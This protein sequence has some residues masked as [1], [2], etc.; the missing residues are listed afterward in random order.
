MDR[1]D[2]EQKGIYQVMAGKRKAIYF[3]ILCLFLPLTTPF[4][5]QAAPRAEYTMP[6]HLIQTVTQQDI[7]EGM[8]ALGMLQCPVLETSDCEKAFE[9]VKECVVRV[10][11]GNAYGSGILWELT[12]DRVVIATNRHVLEYWQAADSYLLFPQGYYLE[13]EILGVSEQ[14][15]VGF[16]AVDSGQFTYEA[17]KELR[18][19][20]ARQEVYERLRQ[21][22]EMFCVGAG[23]EAGEMLFHEAKLEDR[24]RYIADFGAE[25]LYGYGFARTGMSGGGMFD[26]YGYL[27]GM[28]TGGTVHN[29][30]AGVPL[31]A[32]AA[33]YREVMESQD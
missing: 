21:G 4:A 28:V 7:Y 6:P 17:L 20:A 26:G 29:E 10:N 1:S 32:I 9:N 24:A 23:P 8:V 11:M 14:Y 19:V 12:T 16:L 15:D 3:I 2:T 5:V 30:V 27:I 33:A 31:P 13:A 25:M 18:S 22:D